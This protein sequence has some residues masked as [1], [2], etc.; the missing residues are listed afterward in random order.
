MILV[1][2]KWGGLLALDNF[3][4]AFERFEKVVDTSRIRTFQQLMVSFSYWAG[5]NWLGTSKQVGALRIEAGRLG[6]EEAYVETR[7]RTWRYDTF[8]KRGK[9]QGRFRDLKTGRFVKNSLVHVY[10]K[11][12]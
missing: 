9:L 5:R 10:T 12:L 11:G 4:E 6:I 3:P 7:P 1:S 8:I 2:R